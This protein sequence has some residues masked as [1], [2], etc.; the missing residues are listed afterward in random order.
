MMNNET[1][2]FSRADS[3]PTPDSEGNMVALQT[4]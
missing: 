2:F 4:G 1:A 3:L